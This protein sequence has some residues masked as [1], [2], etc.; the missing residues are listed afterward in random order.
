M[1]RLKAWEITNLPMM[2][3]CWASF[4]TQGNIGAKFVSGNPTKK[5]LSLAQLSSRPE[6]S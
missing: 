1:R 2:I 5:T 6:L 3:N 4:F